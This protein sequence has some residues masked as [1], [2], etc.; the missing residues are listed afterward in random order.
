MSGLLSGWKVKH[1]TGEKGT[2]QDV[3]RKREEQGVKHSRQAWV[4]REEE[5]PMCFG[6]AGL[7]LTAVVK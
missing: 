2:E 6:L 1:L 5:R 4:C 3:T 7:S